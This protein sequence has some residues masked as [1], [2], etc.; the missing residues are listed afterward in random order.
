M[1]IR[2]NTACTFFLNHLWVIT[3]AIVEQDYQIGAPGSYTIKRCDRYTKSIDGWDV[4]A[5]SPEPARSY[6]EGVFI[7]GASYIVGGSSY[8]NADPSVDIYQDND[9]FVDD[10]QTWSS[11][12]S[13]P[14]KKYG[15][16]G[17]QL[18]GIGYMGGGA[19]D[20]LFNWSL[21]EFSKV[22]SSMYGYSPVTETWSSRQNLPEPRLF[23]VAFS[24]DTVGAGFVFGGVIQGAQYPDDVQFGVG[25]YYTSSLFRYDDSGDSF[26]QRMPAPNPV[27]EHTGA[28]GSDRYGYT[29][30]RSL[31]TPGEN[32]YQYDGTTDSWAA[33]QNVSYGIDRGSNLAL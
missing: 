19:D 15:H 21:D 13:L 18:N 20:Y 27:F 25:I 7:G 14:V 16:A 32:F 23:P 11:E 1:S 9:K 5:E 24:L 33:K 3:G 2:E 8:S 12:Q 31:R 10:T 29:L 17:F 28:A 6:A 4:R 30:N 26:T 22:K